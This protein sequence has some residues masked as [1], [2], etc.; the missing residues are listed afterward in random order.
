MNGFQSFVRDNWVRLLILGVLLW[1]SVQR[2]VSLE[3]NLVLPPA[4]TPASSQPEPYEMTEAEAQQPVH[5]P[6]TPA[7]QAT[8]SPV[9]SQPVAPEPGPVDEPL[10]A[11]RIQAFVDRFRHVAATEE[12]KF[13]VPAAIILANGLY[14]SRAGTSEAVTRANNYFALPCT[15][16]WKGATISLGGRCYRSYD[17]AWLSFRDH[18][19]LLSP[20]AMRLPANDFAAWARL[21]ENE[22]YHEPGL[23]DRLMTLARRA[24]LQY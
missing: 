21:L 10:S 24:G 3:L 4:T 7:E 1:L 17:N 13:G 8:L 12:K 14:H 16:D 5:Y 6:A 9:P 19:K 22:V 15:P 23:T 20:W 11:T 2:R 18:S